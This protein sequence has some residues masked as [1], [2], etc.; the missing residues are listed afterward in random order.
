MKCHLIILFIFF[1]PYIWTQTGIDNLFYETGNFG[2][3]ELQFKHH[4]GIR[5]KINT[6]SADQFHSGK[7]TEIIL[8]ALPN[9]NT[10]EQ[11]EGKK[12]SPGD[13][14]H[15]DIQHVAA[16][17]RFLRNNINHNY[18]IVYLEAPEKSFPLWSKLRSENDDNLKLTAEVVEYVR[19]I[20]SE[21]NPSITLSGHSGGGRFIFNFID[22][23]EKIP[24][25]VKRICFID[26]NYGY[27]PPHASKLL[28]WLKQKENQLVILSYNDTNVEI[29]GKKIVSQEGGTWGRSFAMLNDLK[30]LG[31]IKSENDSLINFSST[32]VHFILNKN[33]ENKILHTV[34]VELNGIIH[35]QLTG[36]NNESKDY[37]YFGER[38]YL[39]YIQDKSYKYPG[40]LFPPP[41]ENIDGREFLLSMRSLSLEERERSIYDLIIRGNIPKFLHE[42]KPV[43]YEIHG[44]KVR[45]Q[46]MPDYL[47]IGNDSDFVRI[48]LS[49]ATAQRLAD[50][51]NASLPTPL[52]VDKIYQSAEIK[53]EP[54]TFY[55]IENNNEKIEKF[56][57]HNDS[58]NTL[59]GG[60]RGLTAG[61][62]KDVV[63]SSKLDDTLRSRHVIIYGWHRTNGAAI[64][65]ESNIH[66]NRYLDYSHGIRF[67][68]NEIEINGKAFEIE[69]I[70]KDKE[71]YK[72]LLDSPYPLTRTKYSY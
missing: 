35:S 69:E 15:F 10:I 31:L 2:E 43:E 7:M 60:K 66:I 8:Y 13:D 48:P 20:F 51:F 32:N 63:I 53:P 46:V 11:T 12:I 19:S 62:K 58:I 3:R 5:I 16:Q 50:H 41:S 18:I 70:L 59:T 57:E 38:A 42:L 25:Y 22:A 14:W 49:P 52:I 26:S 24:L 64:Q 27:H 30:E 54:V 1:S 67:I 23:F 47:A 4:S 9:G 44:A 37:T 33:R 65:P 21:Y 34:Q 40:L 36:T 29:N 55:P 28:K 72:Y 56:I 71:M 68:K 6:P 45:F 61:I 17:I 39:N